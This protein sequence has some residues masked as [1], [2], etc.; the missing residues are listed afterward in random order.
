MLISTQGKKDQNFST[1][2]PKL[3]LRKSTMTYTQRNTEA[4]GPGYSKGR[5]LK[6][7]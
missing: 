7:G 4:Q 5:S 1:G 6:G 3:T 2:F